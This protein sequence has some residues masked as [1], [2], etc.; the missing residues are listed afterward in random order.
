[1]QN[2]GTRL[3]DTQSLTY[4]EVMALID[5]G[6]QVIQGYRVKTNSLRYKTFRK[7]RCCVACGLEGSFF[8]LHQCNTPGAPADRAHLNFWAIVPGEGVRLMTKDHIVPKSRGGKN[9]TENM[10]TMCYECNQTKGARSI[11]RQ[12]YDVL[13]DLR[14]AEPEVRRRVLL[15]LQRMVT[16]DG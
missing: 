12:V 15:N 10:Q 6:E 16:K 2:S 4:D 5:T 7:S 8:Q 13:E 14:H 9:T 11:E 1:M 3:I